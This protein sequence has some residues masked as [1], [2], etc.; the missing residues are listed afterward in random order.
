ML[1]T[2]YQALCWS[3]ETSK[4]I[5]NSLFCD[6]IFTVVSVKSTMKISSIVVAFLENTNFSLISEN[7][8]NLSNFKKVCKITVPQL[9]TGHV[10]LA[11]DFLRYS[12]LEKLVMNLHWYL[13][14][15]HDFT[16]ILFASLLRLIY[17]RSVVE[18]LT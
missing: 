16:S 6:E 12:K 11:S 14:S 10:N 7:V 13:T 8:F 4:V 17:S 18:S 5:V 2:W 15:E 9:F 1:H 3:H